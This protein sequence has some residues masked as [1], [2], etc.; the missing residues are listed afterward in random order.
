MVGVVAFELLKEALSARTVHFYGLVGII[1]I[2]TT[3]FM[4]RGI[5]GL[6]ESAVARWAARKKA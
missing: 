3:L 4:P 5:H 1:F 6:I 2:V